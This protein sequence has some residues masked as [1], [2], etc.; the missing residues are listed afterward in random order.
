MLAVPKLLLLLFVTHCAGRLSFKLL[1][2]VCL[3][4]RFN[5][6][7]TVRL[8]L[9]TI[10]VVVTAAPTPS[11]PGGSSSGE[12]TTTPPPQPAAASSPMTATALAATLAA[13]LLA[14]GYLL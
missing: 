1:L 3:A 13:S 8:R 14:Y 6:E 5:R 9:L 10:A 12:A 7:F 11:A 2:S 4:C